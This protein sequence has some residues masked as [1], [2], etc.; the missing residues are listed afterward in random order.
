MERRA[1]KLIKQMPKSAGLFLA[2]LLNCLTFTTAIAQDDLPVSN[3]KQYTIGEISVVGAKQ[4]NEQTV[5]A[6]TR[7]RSGERVYLPGDRISN[8]IKRLWDL[9][10]F[11]DINLYA[12]I[13]GDVVDLKFEIEEV[14]ELNKVTINGIKEKKAKDIIKDNDL[15]KGTK[16]TE[17]LI[18]KT[19][20][21]I[22][23]KYK[24]QGYLNSKVS[25]ITRPTSDTTENSKV[26]MLVNVNL[27]DRVKIEDIEFIGNEQLSDGKL[28]KAMKNTKRKNLI[29]F[30]KRS[31]YIAEDFAEDKVSIVDK[32]KERG[33][34][35]ARIVSDTLIL[36]KI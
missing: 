10:L 3:G 28:R 31:K 1:S 4:Y 23:N 24:E 30:W 16:V 33:F 22:E 15:K 21:Y 27:S 34:R 5:I 20:F 6:F 36:V 35:D 11:S 18:T 26:D 17:N 12:T 8:V 7:L 19:K 25:I 2:F 14:P 9:D 29:R 32:Y 13:N